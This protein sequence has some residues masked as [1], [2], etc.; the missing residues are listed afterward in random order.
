MAS[1]KGIHLV[2]LHKGIHQ[3]V[4]D[5]IDVRDSALMFLNGFAVFDKS[6]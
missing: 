2:R 4:G 6:E 3:S 1:S 5:K